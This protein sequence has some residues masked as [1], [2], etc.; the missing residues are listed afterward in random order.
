[1][2]LL[3][4]WYSALNH[5]PAFVHIPIPFWM[6]AVLFEIVGL[7]RRSDSIQ[8]AA[9]WM[10]WLGTIAGT[11][12]VLTG[13]HAASRVPGG[14]DHI[15]ETHK[16]LMLASYFLALGLSILAL[17][18]YGHATYGLKGALLG[19]LVVLSALMILGT[20]RGAEMVGRYGFGV[21]GSIRREPAPLA[22]EAV[23]PASLH[24]VGSK[25]CES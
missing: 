2:G 24:F 3:P 13:L 10:L 6:G 22:K 1:M 23:S 17:F 8:R 11:L 19:G 15:L 9:A 16:E 7:W 25:S 21:N 14:I 4:G 5:H 20:D 18:A 12:A